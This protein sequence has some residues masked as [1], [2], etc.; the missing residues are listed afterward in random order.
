MCFNGSTKWITKHFLFYSIQINFMNLKQ[1]HTMLHFIVIFLS[2]SNV[3]IILSISIH[4]DAT[5]ICLHRMDCVHLIFSKWI[6]EYLKWGKKKHNFLENVAITHRSQKWEHFSHIQMF[7]EHFL[8]NAINTHICN[9]QIL[10]QSTNARIVIMQM[11]FY[12]R[13]KLKYFGPRNNQCL[14]RSRS[15]AQF[16]YNVLNFTAIKKISFGSL[17]RCN[18]YMVKDVAV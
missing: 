11:T 10:V 7:S 9:C 13:C 5:K 3:G 6:T 2:S 14:C 12:L 8:C 18:E 4:G 16:S 15:I 17:T 1:L